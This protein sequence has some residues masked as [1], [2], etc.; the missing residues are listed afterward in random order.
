MT[1]KKDKAIPATNSTDIHV[2]KDVSG[3][4][5]SG[6]N[7]QIINNFNIEYVPEDVGRRSTLSGT[8][9]TSRLPDLRPSSLGRHQG[10][11]IFI[12]YKRNVI[13]D[14][15][16]ATAV[17]D[18]LRQNHDVFIDTTLQVGEKWAERIQNA[19][20]ESDYLIIFLSENSVQSEMVIAEIE[21][22][23]HHH[24]AFGKP[25]ILPV[26]LNYRELL[27]ISYKCLPQSFTM[28]FLGAGNRHHGFDCRVTTSD[29][30]R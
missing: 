22:A 25:V 10:T 11:K 14:T 18:A 24:K 17:F 6:N 15:L 1:R 28:G 21:T 27:G 2:G 12:S 13:P 9:P 8:H 20:K 19:I 3:S 23:Y 16:V 5:I 7:N 29:F 26:R 30:R 4:V